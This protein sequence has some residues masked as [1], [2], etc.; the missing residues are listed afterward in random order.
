M[1]VQAA[2]EIR[3]STTLNF[4]RVVSEAVAAEIVGVS[5]DTLRRVCG[6]GEGPRRIKL[7]PRRVGYRIRDLE[8]W[9]NERSRDS[10]AMTKS[11]GAGRTP[12]DRNLRR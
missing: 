2:R 4:D 6:R 12:A 5:I 11:R 3:E 9:L 10:K 7:S 8:S 1:T